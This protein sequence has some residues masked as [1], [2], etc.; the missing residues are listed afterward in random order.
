MSTTDAAGGDA[1]DALLDRYRRVSNVRHADGILMW[2]QQTKM[3]AGGTPARAEQRST[4]SSLEHDLLTDGELGR[5]LEAV[6]E[7]GL[8]DAERAA[9]AEIRRQH[10]RA[11][12]VPDELVADI[13]RIESSAHETWVEAKADDDFDALAPTLERIVDR[14]RERADHLDSGKHPFEAIYGDSEPFLPI[15]TVEEIF[16]DLKATLVPLVEEIRAA[17]ELPTPFDGTYDERSQLALSEDA[18]DRVGYDWT[19]GRLDTAAHPFTFG[20]QFDCRVTTRFDESDPLAGLTSTVHEFGHATYNLGLPRER[21]GTPL[22]E[23][24]SHGVHESQ[25]RFFENHVGRSKPFWEGFVDTANDR[26]G[27]GA[28]AEAAYAAVNR[29]K[30]DNRIRVEADE[31]TYH[32]HILVRFET[33]KALLGGDIEVSEVPAM[34]NDKME[35]YL[36]VRPET[37]SEGCLQDIHWTAGYLAAFQNYTVGSVLAAQLDAAMREEL[38]DVDALIRDGEFGPV[39]EWLS[40]NVHR[41]GRRYPTD[42]LV[43]EATGEPLSADAFREYAT[44]KFES[45]YGL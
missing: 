28:S 29:V 15:S 21:Y 27:S 11:D 26:L 9:V 5:L 13:A 38:D 1:Y 32:L 4:L 39:H 36:G 40:E 25:S 34:W 43:A 14:Y 33:E 41:H 6:D 22:G 31:L 10:E 42:E 30:P 37:D 23:S 12:R 20:N 2:D 17:G 3:P 18:L 44:A 8:D 45:L 16:E 19:R 35:E 24:G 7:G